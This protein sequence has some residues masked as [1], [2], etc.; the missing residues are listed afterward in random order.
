MESLADLAW[1]TQFITLHER[2]PMA[3]AGT[4]ERWHS[5]QGEELE[6]CSIIVTDANAFIRPI[7]DRMPVVLSPDLGR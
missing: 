2:E 1:N 6:S 4:W 3:L 5:P 7:H